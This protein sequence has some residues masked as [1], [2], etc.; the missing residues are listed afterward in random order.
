MGPTCLQAT[1]LMSE[2]ELGK[3]MSNNDHKGDQR[4]GN[5]ISWDLYYN[6]GLIHLG[7]IEKIY[8]GLVSIFRLINAI[9]SVMKATPR[10]KETSFQDQI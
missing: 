9:I 2:S 8:L 10:L 1:L 4:R 3:C 7:L 6:L 5:E